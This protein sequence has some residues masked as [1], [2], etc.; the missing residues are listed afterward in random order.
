MHILKVLQ[1]IEE[2]EKKIADLYK[3]F[4]EIFADDAEAAAFFYRVSIDETVHANLVAYQRRVAIQNSKLCEEIAFDLEDLN[5]TIEKVVSTLLGPPPSLEEAVKIAIDIEKNATEAH[6]RTAIQQAFP[7][8]CQLLNNLSTFDSRHCEVF[9]DFASDRGFPFASKVRPLMNAQAGSSTPERVA[10]RAKISP[11]K[12]EKIEH[13]YKF[14]K[15]M[16]FYKILGVK[17]YASNEEIKTAFHSWAFEFHP[18]SHMNAVEEIQK[19]LNVIFAYVTTAYSTLMDA[20][21]RKQY[22]MTLTTLRK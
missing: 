5:A 11:E 21:T 7:D 20:V 14:H 1:P 8:I 10:P 16:N 9:E 6:Y 13:Y 18:D 19:K 22:D 12:L 4:S 2:L 17:E 15:N 3:W